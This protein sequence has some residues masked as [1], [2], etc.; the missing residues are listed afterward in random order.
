VL[1]FDRFRVVTFDC[2]GTLIDWERG[3]LDA[4]R[5]VCTRHGV[6]RADD[7]L[8]ALFA[9]TEAPI[10][11]ERFR[12]YRQVLREAMRRLAREL[13]FEPREEEVDAL[14]RTL[15]SWPP[16]P[17]TVPALQR[18]GRRFAL[19]V[20]SNV[21]D[22]LFAGSAR[23]LGVRFDW[24]VTAQQVGSYKPARANFHRALERIGH[25]WDQVV[26]VAQSLFHDVGPARSLGLATVWV[27]RRAGRAGSGATPPAEVLPDQEVPDLAT[28]AALAVPG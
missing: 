16:F 27:N 14:A 11:Q 22:D 28:L 17:D 26:H 18:L 21:D 3:M 1:D 15:P 20:I 24:V 23:Q 7:K 25:P 8:L 19:G 12:P 4:L 9:R 6:S 5:P 10:Q 13:G 2:Y